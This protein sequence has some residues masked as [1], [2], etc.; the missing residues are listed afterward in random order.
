[1]KKSKMIQLVMLV[2]V[3]L[4]F[5]SK[6]Y[7]QNI[8]PERTDTVQ[9]PINFRINLFTRWFKFYPNYNRE[10]FGNA[11]VGTFA[12]HTSRGGFGKSGIGTGS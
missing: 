1:M 3:L 6:L 11:R 4:S 7:A 8:Q 2:S 5:S 9:R 12:S 10:H